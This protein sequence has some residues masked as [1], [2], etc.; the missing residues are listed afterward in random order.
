MSARWPVI[1]ATWLGLVLAL[2]CLGGPGSSGSG[3]PSNNEV[4][5]TQQAQIAA[6]QAQIAA[7]QQQ[8]AALQT[9]AAQQRPGTAPSTPAGVSRLFIETLV[10]GNVQAASAM[11]PAAQQARFSAALPHLVSALNGCGKSVAEFTPGRAGGVPQT[12]EAS[13]TPPCGN[14]A[15][16]AAAANAFFPGSYSAGE[17]QRAGP[18]RFCQFQLNSVNDQWRITLVTCVYPN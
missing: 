13:F 2:G 17:L 16:A 4:V 11:A 8:V 12:V 7:Q 15:S 14:W 1:W 18:V 3:V 9:A 5:A 6:A 10:A